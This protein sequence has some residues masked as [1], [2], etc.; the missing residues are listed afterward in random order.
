M[1]L[2]NLDLRVRHAASNMA[3]EGLM[4]LLDLQ[5]VDQGHLA[6]RQVSRP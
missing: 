6:K 2:T 1:F 5:Q 4:I 3:L